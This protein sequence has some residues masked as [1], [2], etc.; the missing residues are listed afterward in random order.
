VRAL[1]TGPD[2]PSARRPA[3]WRH[4]NIG[5]L[6]NNAVRRFEARVLDLMAASGHAETRIA[7]VNLTRNLDIEGTRLTELARRASMS[8]QAM[9]ELVDQ[10]A[11]FGL[12][13]R[14]IDPDDRRARLIVFTAA[15]LAWLDAFRAAVDAAENEMR[16][17]LGPKTMS[18]IANGLM[19][20]GAKFDTLKHAADSQDA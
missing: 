20:Y 5:R 6:L 18:E 12:V 14:T 19:A 4:A 17:E 1:V 7:H 13:R 8:K 16:A 3:A 10:C 15:G 11:A 2:I 9:G